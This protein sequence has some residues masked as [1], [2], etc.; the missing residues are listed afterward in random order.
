MAQV[1]QFATCNAVHSLE[2]RLARWLLST[3]DRVGSA[4]LPLTQE[5]IGEML[6][7][8]RTTVIRIAKSLQAQ[9]VI[10]YG[11]GRVGIMNRAGLEQTACECYRAVAEHFKRTVPATKSRQKSGRRRNG[12]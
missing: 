12:K 11:R 5:T 9:G 1:L 2:Q 8:H 4:E 3:H 6:G 7:V 10:R